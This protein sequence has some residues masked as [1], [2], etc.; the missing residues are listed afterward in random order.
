MKRAI[1]ILEQMIEKINIE[2]VKTQLVIDEPEMLRDYHFAVSDMEN[3]KMDVIELKQAIEILNNH[4]TCN[5]HQQ[6]KRN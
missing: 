5:S 6:K 2:M 3:F 4:F 1:R